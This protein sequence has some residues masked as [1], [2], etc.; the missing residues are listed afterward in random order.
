M[1]NID[2]RVE[3]KYWVNNAFICCW[4]TKNIQNKFLFAIQYLTNFKY[5]QRNLDM[6]VVMHE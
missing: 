1:S 4:L 3:C 5:K 6:T 2:E